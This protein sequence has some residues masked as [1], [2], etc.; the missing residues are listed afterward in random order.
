LSGRFLA[1]AL[2]SAVS[3]TAIFLLWPGLGLPA[4]GEPLDAPFPGSWR[5]FFAVWLP[6][7]FPAFTLLH[8]RLLRW[9]AARGLP[10]GPARRGR[11]WDR[12]SYV[13]LPLFVLLMVTWPAVGSWRLPFALF[14]VT[15]LAAKVLAVVLV[16]YRAWVAAA[17]R[18]EAEA[19]GG[20][21]L[22][23]G[24]YL[25]WTA[26]LL[27]AFA[28][29]YVATA[30]S[31]AG[32]EHLYLLNAQSLYA[33]RDL[34]L[35]NNVEQRDDARFYW[36]RR[37]PKVLTRPFLG[38][39]A[40]L[41]PGYALGSALLPGYPLGARLGAVLTIGACAALMG[42]QVY[43]LCRDLG[44]SAMG[45]LWAW[46]VVALTPPVL[47]NSA[48]VYPELP[49]ALLA[50]VGVRALLRLPASTW[51]ALGIVAASAAALV[52]LKDRYLPIA[53]GLFAW[54][55]VGLW[56][57]RRGLALGLV[58]ALVAA[59]AYVLAVD[60]LPWLLPNFR[61]A[62][63][64]W[65]VL[66]SWNTWMPQA[67]LG[68]F[69]DQEFGLLYYAPHWALAAPGVLLL[70]RRR[71]AA[72]IAL[73]AIVVLY[74]AAVV[75]WRWLQWDAGWT[76]PP[77]FVLC[78]TPL[79]A[80]FVAEVF[81]R[82][83]GRV[84]ATVNTLCT[85]WS[86]GLGFVLVLQPFWRYNNLDGRSTL[87]Q[88]AGG[89]LGLDLARFLP[90]LRFPTD[91][92][93]GILAACLLLL[94]AGCWYWRAGRYTGGAEGWGAGSVLLAPVPAAGLVAGLL[95]VWTVLAVTVPTWAVDGPA[96]RHSAGIQFGSYQ[97]QDVVWVMTRPGEVSERIVTW[98]GVTEITIVAG[99]YSTIAGKPGM[100]LFLD[101]T[102]V[103]AWRLEAGRRWV[104][105][106]YT[107]RAQTGFGRPVL[108]L[109]FSDLVDRR[110]A[111]QMQHAWVGRVRLKRLP[112][113]ATSTGAS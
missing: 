68:L 14:F 92:T 40:L 48:H 96:M 34:D 37:N 106:E 69:L 73:V 87:V 107:A 91:W 104:K 90:S 84:L 23:A 77:R 112:A 4:H 83:R 43:R 18:E 29:A 108:R 113:S 33:D 11:A 95:I 26:F 19:A 78:A 85:T 20:D 50:V 65:G 12:G 58:G 22:P 64:L 21:P 52:F 1:G 70:W 5:G 41:L 27:Y 93:W 98:P 9:S 35:H 82:G 32:D 81:D 97:H 88:L 72:A 45:S 76:P 103:Q 8:E 30:L 62:G 100:R 49:A 10:E 3:G 94:L 102:E 53:L 101:Q 7:L 60:P 79:L 99:G 46:L 24:R 56:R 61:R 15:V 17:G 71:P 39:P 66:G 89:A 31:T 74:V 6:A 110:D 86:A 2:A 55:V 105:R 80:P 28:G 13:L 75:K 42:A 54:A 44:A 57:R 38:F 109:E 111:G 63:H 16:G 59:G 51:P 47:V 67:L 36:G 25:F